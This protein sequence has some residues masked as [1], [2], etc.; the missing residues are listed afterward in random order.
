MLNSRT[1]TC[2]TFHFRM[3]ICLF[4]RAAEHLVHSVLVVRR[5]NVQRAQFFV[6]FEELVGDAVSCADYDASPISAGNRVKQLC[7]SGG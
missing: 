2:T 3:A 1:S 4:A 5:W 6:V 7:G